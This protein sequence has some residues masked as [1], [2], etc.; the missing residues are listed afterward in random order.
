MRCER[1]RSCY[2]WEAA[3]A[4]IDQLVGKGDDKVSLQK[5]VDL[6]EV[7]KIRTMVMHATVM[8]VDDADDDDDDGDDDDDYYYASCKHS[9][10]LHDA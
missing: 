8:K 3:A 5:L 2:L 10:V 6:L 9:S 4:A 7:N 1:C